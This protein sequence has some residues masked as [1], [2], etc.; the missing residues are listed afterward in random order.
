MH[1][2]TKN[3]EMLARSAAKTRSHER[4]KTSLVEKILL[5]AIGK[6]HAPVGSAQL[7]EELLRHGFDLTPRAIRYHLGRMDSAGWTRLWNRRQG[8]VLTELGRELLRSIELPEKVGFVL[9]RI[10]ELSYR[11]SYDPTQHQGTVIVNTAELSERDLARAVELLPPVARADL[12]ISGRFLLARPK[13]SIE[14]YVV[15][16][17]TVVLGSMCSI[18]LNG[19]LLKAGIPVTSRYGGL[20]EIVHGRPTR[21]LELIEYSGTTRDPLALFIEAGLTRTRDVLRTGRGTVCASFREVPASSVDTL[22]VILRRLETYAIRAVL[23]VGQP[24]RPLLDI[25]VTDGRAGLVVLGG[26]NVMAVMR[27]TGIPF[28]L[29]PMAALVDARRLRPFE[30]LLPFARRPSPLID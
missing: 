18:T 16:E 22:R 25:P 1:T 13:E 28:S 10:D 5:R 14:D 21:F 7:A 4:L 30:E 11:M 20:L 26:L 29:R 15:P 9:S 27:E 3:A 8:R 2:D 17:D 24:G 6:S 12:S 19:I 23:A